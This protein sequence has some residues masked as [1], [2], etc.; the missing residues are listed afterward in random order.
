MTPA[1]IKRDLDK[2]QVMITALKEQL[3]TV[4]DIKATSKST[5][6]SK[7]TKLEK[8]I[9]LTVELS[10]KLTESYGRKK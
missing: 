1:D 3:R 4:R 8:H 7:L 10:Q 9:A 6:K 2:I 5:F